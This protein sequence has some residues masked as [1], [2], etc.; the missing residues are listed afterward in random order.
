MLS[1]GRAIAHCTGIG[2]SGASQS[3]SAIDKDG[4]HASFEI[5]K[6]T[7]VSRERTGD[8][9]GTTGRDGEREQAAIKGSD[10]SKA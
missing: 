3:T 7:V 2:Q 9:L 10:E 4:V 1:S 5:S 6:A 8:T